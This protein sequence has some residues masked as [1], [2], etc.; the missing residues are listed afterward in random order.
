MWTFTA[1]NSIWTTPAFAADGSSFWG[2]LDLDVY[3]IDSHG[4]PLWHAFT[5]GY[6]VS[7]PAIGSDGTVYVGSFDSKLYALNPSTGSPRWTFAT[8]DH[9]YSSPA[10]DQDATGHT[11]AIY[12]GS[13]DGS[14]YALSPS[15]R[16]LWRYDTGDPI[17]S[18]PVLG[19]A[20][21]GTHGE[22]LYVGS[23][24]GR[25]YAL[26]AAT[27]RRRWS[28]DTTPSDP[29]LR[30]RN[31]LNASPALGTTGVYIAGEHGYV[32]YVPY[33]YCLHRRDSPLFHES[34]TGAWQ[35]GQSR[36]RRQR[37]GHDASTRSPS[38]ASPPRRSSTSGSSSAVADGP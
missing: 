9:I 32:D 31:D 24:N 29:A 8:S 5:P 4:R 13:T 10:L 17:R 25:L 16:L 2:S 18:S 15:G 7:S 37:R 6:V 28:F 23:S 3:H 14:V 26:D 33:D 34:G 12:I 19:P 20:P 30:D 11:T 36:V 27:G 38:R 21:A 35:S 22:I 1:G